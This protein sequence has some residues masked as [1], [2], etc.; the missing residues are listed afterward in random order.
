[1]LSGISHDLRTPLTRIKLQLAVIKDKDLSEKISKDVDEMEKMLNEYLQFTS[2]GAKDKTETFDISELTDE[3]IQ[4]MK[5]I[6]L[7]RI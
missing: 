7:K 3:I 4:N 2:T 1:M 6:I 5:I